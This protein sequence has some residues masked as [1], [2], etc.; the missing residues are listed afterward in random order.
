M[1]LTPFNRNLTQKQLKGKLKVTIKEILT[2]CSTKKQWE[3]LQTNRMT[4][5]ERGRET[6]A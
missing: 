4:I 5:S 2:E 1:R 6:N 3:I